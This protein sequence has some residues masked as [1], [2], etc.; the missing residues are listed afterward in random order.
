MLVVTNIKTEI[1]TIIETN[2]KF[3]TD[4]NKPNETKHLKNKHTLFNI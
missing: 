4:E 1:T 2:Q 3:K